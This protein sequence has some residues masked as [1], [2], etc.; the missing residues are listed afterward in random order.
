MPE[1][2]DST[3]ALA[4][5]VRDGVRESLHR[6]VLVGLDAAGEV[7]LA[8]GDP[9]ATVLP[10]SSLK[11]VQALVALRAGAPVSGYALA[12]AAA[13]HS[14]TDPH[15]AT[16]REVLSRAGL[17]EDD[18]QCPADLPMD[19]EAFAHA[20]AGGEG[21]TRARHNC[22]GK[23]AAMLAACVASGWPTATYLEQD[24]PLQL[25]VHAEVERLTGEPVR[26]ATVD[27]CGA[28]LFGTSVAGLARAIRAVAL[29]PDGEARAVADAMRAHPEAVAG[30][31]QPNTV[32]MQ[33]V[34]GLLA[35]GGYEGVLVVVAATGQAVAVKVSD[36]G[37]R[38]TTMVAVAALARLGADVSGARDLTSSPVLGGGRQLG[39]LAPVPELLPQG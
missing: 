36:G 6:G 12:L 34:P 7:A 1:A 25:A 9:D 27:G 23:H 26:A 33:R 11:P 2:A 28:P 24:H 31:G 29:A 16:T 13:S 5:L 3:A 17:A 39:V 19:E 35:K 8:L 4:V 15:A 14:G 38:A 21:R 10:R 18:L 37:S 30:P 32:L 22:S 20:L